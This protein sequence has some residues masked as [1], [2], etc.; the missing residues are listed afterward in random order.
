MTTEQFGPLLPTQ[1]WDDLDAVIAAANNTG[2]GLGASVWTSDLELAGKVAMRLEA[3][4]VWVNDHAGKSAPTVL[5]GAKESGLGIEGGEL[6][7]MSDGQA[8]IVYLPKRIGGGNAGLGTEVGAAAVVANGLEGGVNGVNGTAAEG[9]AKG[10]N[11][12]ETKINGERVNGVG[13]K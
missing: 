13:S 9:E 10:V 5:A 1:P 3:G 2:Y 6:G 11:G 12:L 7:L 4:S 8:K